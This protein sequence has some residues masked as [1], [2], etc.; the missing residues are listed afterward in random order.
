MTLTTRSAEPTTPSLY[1][2]LELSK[3]T[4]KLAFTTSRAK[5]ARIRDVKA[6]DQAAFLAEIDAAKIRLRLPEDA[7]V[8]SCYE[9]GRDGFQDRS[10]RRAEAGPTPGSAPRRGGG[11]ARRAGPSP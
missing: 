8:K 11:V 7:P 1:V 9:A 5:R 2:A 4:W 10:P 3:D 6:R